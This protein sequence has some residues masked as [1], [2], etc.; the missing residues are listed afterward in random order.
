MRTKLSIVGAILSAIFSATGFAFNAFSVWPA[1]NWGLIALIAFVVFVVIVGQGWYA[2]EH[3]AKQYE[4]SRP[5]IIYKQI[6]ARQH[7]DVHRKPIYWAV[8]VWFVNSPSITSEHSTA[9]NVT[10]TVTFYD[11]EKKKEFEMYGCFTQPAV[12]ESAAINELGDLRDEIA[13]WSPNAIPQKLLLALKW[14]DDEIAYG[15]ARSN[16]RVKRLKAPGRELMKGL[17]FIEVLFSGV[18]IDRQLFWFSLNNLGQGNN[19]SLTGPIKPPN[20][21]RKGSQ[22]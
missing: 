17:H 13:T 10:A 16:L 7:I 11:E 19:L 1:I 5:K 21:H 20:L 22:I 3:R 15:L 9:K 8:Q 4:T 18:G 14:P 12:L 6:I 2:S